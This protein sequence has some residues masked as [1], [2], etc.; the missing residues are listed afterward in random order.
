MK[1]FGF[2]PLVVNKAEDCM[3][4]F[5]RFYDFLNVGF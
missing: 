3:N 4:K 2:L 5:Y 1:E